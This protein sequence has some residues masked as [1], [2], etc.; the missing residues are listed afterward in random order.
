MAIAAVL[1]GLSPAPALAQLA[2]FLKWVNDM[3]GQQMIGVGFELPIR[4]TYNNGESEGFFDCANFLGDANRSDARRNLTLGVRGAVLYNEKDFSSEENLSNISQFLIGPSVIWA[5]KQVPF[6]DLT[7]ALQFGPFIGKGIEHKWST[8]LDFGPVF[9]PFATVTG[10]RGIDRFGRSLRLGV[11]YVQFLNSFS[12]EDFG[13]PN[14][15]VAETE[16]VWTITIGF[17]LGAG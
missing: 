8:V 1:V 3:S 4:C 9:K 5:P 6:L 13:A 2:D 16:G 10:E 17:D 11:R 12:G 14:T 15:F 7:A